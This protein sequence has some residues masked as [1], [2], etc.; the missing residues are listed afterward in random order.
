MA[1]YL[2]LDHKKRGT[3]LQMYDRYWDKEKKEVYTEEKHLGRYGVVRNNWYEIN[4]NS[5][6]GPGEPNV[7]DTPDNPDDDDAGFVNFTI[8][9]LS[10]AK[11]SQSVDL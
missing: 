2:R 1:Y 4:V 10:W 3:Y 5:I 11:R 8:Q 7:P 9:I 6:S